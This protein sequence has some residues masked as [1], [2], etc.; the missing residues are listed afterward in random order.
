VPIEQKRIIQSR[1]AGSVPEDDGGSIAGAAVFCLVTVGLFVAA[2]ASMTR[3]TPLLSV[4]PFAVLALVGIAALFFTILRQADSNQYGDVP[5]EVD[6]PGLADGRHW[7]AT[8]RLPK[9]ASGATVVHAELLCNKVREA[10]DG[11]TQDLVWGKG[12]SFGIRWVYGEGTAALSFE[13]PPGLPRSETRDSNTPQGHACGKWE[14]K[15]TAGDLVRNYDLDIQPASG[16]FAPAAIDAPEEEVPEL[17][18][19]ASSVAM[20]VAANLVL[21][22]GIAFWGW[23]VRDVAL[24]YWF[25]NLVV[26]A[27]S[28][29]AILIA[30]PRQLAWLERQGIAPSGTGLFIGKLCMAVFFVVHFGIFC[31]VHA[32]LLAAV[33]LSDGLLEDGSTI[34][35]LL[36]TTLRDPHALAAIGAI[37]ISHGYSF[38]HDYVGRGEYRHANVRAMMERPYRRVAVASLFILAGVGLLATDSPLPVIAGL[39][40]VKTVLDVVAHFA[41][42]RALSTEPED[43]ALFG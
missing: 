40:A 8:L 18:S 13:I 14:L 34:S 3:H 26:G 16:T 19:N 12:A 22:A 28:V 6:A 24:L 7:R 15:I 11:E 9:A 25:E 42:R 41:E 33:F 5:L 1:E 21:I 10:N 4:L 2:F 20:L 36:A 38:F 43:R 17:P 23:R 35:R 29:V 37:A 39:V 32:E 31:Y 30:V 27:F